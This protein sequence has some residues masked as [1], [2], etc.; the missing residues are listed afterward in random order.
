MQRLKSTAAMFVIMIVNPVYGLSADIFHAQGEL[1]GEVT[2]TS[3]LL[4]SR[5]TAIPGP[6]LDE[7]GDIPGAAGIACFEYS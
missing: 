5:L 7:S 4:Q 1:A 6:V 2:A 3:V